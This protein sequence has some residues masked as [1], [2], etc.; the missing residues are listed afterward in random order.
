MYRGVKDSKAG[1]SETDVQMSLNAIEVSREMPDMRDTE[2]RA[3]KL[4][5][6]VL[7]AAAICANSAAAGAAEAAAEA[8]QPSD[9]TLANFL[10]DG[11]DQDWT[12][13]HRLTPD[14]S[15]LKVQTNFM[16]MEYRFDYA[17][18]AGNQHLKY[19]DIDFV[20]NLIAYSPSRRVQIEV[21]GNNQWNSPNPQIRGAEGVSGPAMGGLVRFQLVD[22]MTS[23]YAFQARVATANQALGQTQDLTTYSLA[24]WNDLQALL[25]LDRTGL[26]YSVQYDRWLGSHGIG[27]LESDVGYDVSV[28][29]TWTRPDAPVFGRFTTFLEAY[30]TT[31]LD[32][33]YQD[34]T[35]ATLTPGVRFWFLPKHSLTLGID[36][37][38]THP[39]PFG[40]VV[41]A[42]Y[43]YNFF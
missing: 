13:R 42:T 22:T 37:P 14:M 12:Q 43:I 26:Y 10:S 40:D 29:K 27:A 38:V 6:G 3:M 8:T 2:R 7:F 5:R 4:C 11:W 17:H 25:G 32:G 30:A 28:A 31:N 15:L 36:L 34:R 33:A 20:N 18:T 41:R 9:L 35:I 19:S 21:F 39:T 16:E 1:D 23:S 24:G